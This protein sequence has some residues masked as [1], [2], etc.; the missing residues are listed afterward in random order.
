[1]SLP[2]PEVLFISY[3]RFVLNFPLIYYA[4]TLII[5]VVVWIRKK[6]LSISLLVAYCFM[7]Y[8]MAVLHR[9]VTPEATYRCQLFW[10]W[11]EWESLG[12]QIIANILVFIPIGYLSGC[13]WKWKGEIFAVSFSV[14]IEL[15]QLILHRGLFEFD[16][17]LHNTV[18]AGIGL[19]VWYL[20]RRYKE[21]TVLKIG[22]K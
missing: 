7:M 15:S 22:L 4:L 17:M 18:G 16:D 8:A 6:K 9:P 1:M 2:Y 21:D 11:K 12:L 13:I 3:V 14:L 10:S 5:G 20:V 19:V